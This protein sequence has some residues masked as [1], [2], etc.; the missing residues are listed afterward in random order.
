MSA[1]LLT[2]ARL[3]CL[4]LLLVFSCTS[5]AQASRSSQAQS[6]S[7]GKHGMVVFG[8]ESALYA[9][10]M[11]MFHAPHDFQVVIQFH[12]ADTTVQNKLARALATTPQ[13]WSLDPEDFD[14]QR[15]SSNNPKPITQFTARFVEGHFER[16]GTERYVAQTVVVDKV[17]IFRRIKSEKLVDT[18]GR[19]HLIGQGKERFLVKEIDRRP[20]FDVIFKLSEFAKSNLHKIIH[21][22][23]STLAFPEASRLTKQLLNAKDKHRSAGAVLYFETEDLQ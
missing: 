22:P 8:G 18:K 19:Y 10:H 5:E 4:A 17:L 16:G 9:S 6:A 13:F 12:L 14:L 23:D 15:F 1:T 7:W 2:I 21:F 20:D 11:P 3:V